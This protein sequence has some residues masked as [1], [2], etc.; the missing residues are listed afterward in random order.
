MK[1]LN[2]NEAGILS[3]LEPLR[4]RQ[5][6]WQMICSCSIILGIALFRSFWRRQYG[7][8]TMIL[9][10]VCILF[11]GVGIFA[12]Y[13]L[14]MVR[15][16]YTNT[17]KKLLAEKVLQACFEDAHYS[18]EQGFSREE[19][20]MAGV[21][22]LKGHN[23]SY[24]SEDL[25]T[26][27][28]SGVEFKQSDVRVTHRSA[29]KNRRTIVDVDGRLTRF[30]YDKDILGRI[31]IT[32]KAF[33]PASGSSELYMFGSRQDV[34]RALQN[35]MGNSFKTISME[36][37]DFNQR[38]T[39]YATDAHSVY[40]LLTPPVMEY[41]KHLCSMDQKLSISFD[42]TFL[43]ILRTGKGGIFEPPS[44]R[45]LNISDEVK[46]S[47]RELQEIVYCIEALRLDERKE[48]EE[49]LKETGKKPEIN[50]QVKNRREEQ[51]Y[52]ELKET[53]TGYDA[54]VTQVIEDEDFEGIGW[55]KPFKGGY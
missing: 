19:F 45:T 10:V 21:F 26:G 53:G 4:K 37:V 23:Y 13:Q 48:R 24:H 50:E 44:E 29:G 31:L 5:V 7:G 52:K 12:G 27:I 54:E 28:Q 2:L 43:Y 11:I 39:V 25:I 55:D 8:G 42:G 6:L 46:K 20:S 9:V 16:Q 3:I 40:Y 18:P 35:S 41:L 38:F 32:S 49:G 15:K 51:L 14:T 36:D 22:S 34:S 1:E 33:M 17:Y 47:Y 30:R